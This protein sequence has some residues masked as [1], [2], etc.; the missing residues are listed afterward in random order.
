MKRIYAAAAVLFA[1]AALAE[2]L[3]DYVASATV[4]VAGGEGLHRLEVPFEVHRVAKADLSDLRMFNARG[5]ALPFAFAGIPAEAPATRELVSLPLFPV[6]RYE[7][8]ASR[9]GSTTVSAGDDVSLDVRA[10]KNGTLISLRT[11]PKAEGKTPAAVAAAP[12]VVSWVADASAT[13]QPVGAAVIDWTP[14]PGTEIVRVSLEASD[15]LKSW[16]PLAS[17]SVV[18][19]EQEGRKLSQPRLEFPARKV[20]YVRATSSTPGFVLGGLRIEQQSQVPSAEAAVHAVTVGGRAGARPGEYIYDLQA[21]IP[22]SRVQLLLGET[23]A[24]APAAIYAGNDGAKDSKTWRQVGGATFYRLS[25]GGT[26][27]RSPPLA[28]P[29]TPARYWMVRVDPKA[30]TPADAPRL[31]VAYRPRQVVFASRGEGPYQLA[32]GRDDAKRADLQL[33]TLIPG[34]ERGGEFKLPAAQ[35]GAIGENGPP[36]QKSLSVAS[37]S[38]A[39]MGGEGGRK[40]VLWIVLVGAVLMLGFMAWRLSREVK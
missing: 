6:H 28:I 4:T 7:R 40:V 11:K 17:G 32:F 22:V 20:K 1:G 19:L 18:A 24:V 33:E 37:V 14:G 10:D 26:E 3:S 23:N 38:R 16:Q 8:A 25:R 30:G 31:E 21:A 5:D 35:I 13:T 15:D 39:M 36:E 9:V 12:A 2:S 27:V 34:Y 29:A